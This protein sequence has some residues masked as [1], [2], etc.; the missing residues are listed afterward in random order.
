M[1]PSLTRQPVAGPPPARRLPLSH[2]GAPPGQLLAAALGSLLAL[3]L[4]CG[5]FLWTRTGQWLDGLLLPRAERGGSYEQ[6]TVLLGP[7]KAVLALFGSPLVLALLLGG[8]LLV[9]LLRRRPAAGVAGVGLVLTTVAVAGV[10][11][12]LLPRPEF[13]LGDGSAHNSFPSGHVSAA[14]ALLLAFLLVLPGRPR[15]WLAVPGAAGVSVVAAA[16]MIAGWHRFSDALGGVLLA[17][18]LFCLA[19]AALAGGPGGA[20]G[21]DRWDEPPG[22]TGGMAVGAVAVVGALLAVV[23]AAPL[24]GGPLLAVVAATGLT[25]LAVAS[26]VFLLDSGGPTVA[27]IPPKSPRSGGQGRISVAGREPDDN[28]RPKW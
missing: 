9:G 8:V 28:R 19:A 4:T 21:Q 23:C 7:A 2:R 10:A 13:P 3:G 20:G 15:R 27:G 14:A 11:K 22:G 24:E 26:A 6:R 5:A 18:A 17:V 1:Y 25:V 12:S 16:T